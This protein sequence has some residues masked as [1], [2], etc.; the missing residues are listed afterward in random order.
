MQVGDTVNLIRKIT[1]EVLPVE[2]V[3]VCGG[4][5]G[6]SVLVQWKSTRHRY[7]LDL[8]KNEVLAVDSTQGHR[9]SMRAW[10]SINEEHRKQLTELCIARKKGRR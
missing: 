7:K 2:L 6:M 5:S 9:Q 3:E 1:N 8:V 10:Y 4:S